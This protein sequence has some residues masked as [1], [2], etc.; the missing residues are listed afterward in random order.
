MDF[1]LKLETVKIWCKKASK[2]PLWLCDNSTYVPGFLTTI[3][4]RNGIGCL[5]KKVLKM[6][7]CFSSSPCISYSLQT[8]SFDD[9]N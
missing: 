4:D 5:Q 9:G 7:S 3:A 1:D 8:Q 6:P 2:Q